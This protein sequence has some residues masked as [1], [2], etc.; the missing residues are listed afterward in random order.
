MPPR[1]LGVPCCAVQSRPGSHAPSPPLLAA[2][3]PVKNASPRPSIVAVRFHA[4]L[5]FFTNPSSRPGDAVAAPQHPA[6]PRGPWAARRTDG[7]TAWQGADGFPRAGPGRPLEAQSPEWPPSAALA[8]QGATAPPRHRA[9][10]HGGGR[11][12]KLIKDPA[13][14][15][16]NGFAAAPPRPGPPRRLTAWPALWPRAAP[17]TP[18]IRADSAQNAADATSGGKFQN[19]LGASSLPGMR[20]SRRRA[21]QG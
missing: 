18:S 3:S 17:G 7:P 5:R 2:S 4:P 14:D 15:L 8:V 12:W 16:R 21:A 11:A 20:A 6:P 13:W 19:P 9:E 10:S 1:R